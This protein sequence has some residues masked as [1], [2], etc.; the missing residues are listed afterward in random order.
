MKHAHATSPTALQ[1]NIDGAFMTNLH[2]F[3]S[4]GYYTGTTEIPVNPV[5]GKPFTINESVATLDPL[6]AYMPEVE[7]ARRVSGAWV[8]EALPLPEPETVPEHQP[9]P[10]Y[11]RYYGNQKLDL[12][13]QAEQLAVVTATMSDPLVK[14]MYDRMIGAAYLSYADH[15]TEYG[16]S[17]LVGKG[18]LTPERKGE[19]VALMQAS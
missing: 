8:V 16:L 13:T 3:N 19:I 15:E 2:H 4:T 7:R 1:S 12:F 14:L 9:E 10:Q 11:P 17:L 6:P 18:L 5:T